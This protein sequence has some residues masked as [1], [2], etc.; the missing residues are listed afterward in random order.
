MR[1]R[2]L[3]TL[4]LT[5]GGAQ[6]APMTV[7]A[8]TTIIADF[9]KVVGGHRVKV[10]VIVPAGG[11]THTFQP[12]PAALRS[13]SGSR[14]LFINGA[15]LEPWLPRVRAAAPRVPVVTLTA[16]LKLH[17]AEEEHGEGGHGEHGEEHGHGASDPHAWWD[18]TLAVGYARAVEK[19]LTRLDPAGKKTYANNLNAFVEKIIGLDAYAKKQFATVLAARR[20]IVTNHDSLRYFA[21]HYG[22]RLVGVVIPGLSTEREPSAR[23][24]ASLVQNVKKSGARVIFTENT[25]NARLAQTLARETGAKVAP[26]LYTD[27]LGPAGGAGDTYLKAFR[28]NVDS[29][30]RALR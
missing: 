20:Q 23:E 25:V 3:T 27:A 6:A 2:L 22:L 30:V 14:A 21:E 28:A 17:P 13:L 19:A 16:G 18:P 15:G 26:P 8:T 10:N 29:V 24:L 5:A 11:D 4:L 7:S 9:V 12:S 1:R